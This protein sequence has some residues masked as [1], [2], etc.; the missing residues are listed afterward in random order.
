MSPLL[1]PGDCFI[2]SKD[3]RENLVGF[4]L[5]AV[6]GVGVTGGRTAAP[7]GT[8]TASPLNMVVPVCGGVNKFVVRC[9]VSRY[10]YIFGL[11][12]QLF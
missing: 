3:S 1:R 2:S 10:I 11:R 8:D 7:E 12:L 4:W 6:G 9:D 5:E